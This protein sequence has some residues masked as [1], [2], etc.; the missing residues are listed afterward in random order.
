[1]T[2]ARSGQTATLLADGR[3]LVA[4]GYDGSAVL[5]SAETY[6]PAK[7]TFSRTGS[8]GQPHDGGTAT[9]LPDGEVLM[10]GGV[11]P[12]SPE[13]QGFA[14]AEL[15]DPGTGK[16]RTTGSM[17]QDRWSQAAALLA[18][19]KVLVAG[20]AGLPADLASAELYDPKTGRFAATGSMTQARY[21]LTA[22]SLG[23][24]RVLVA[25]GWCERGTVA[26]AEL[27]DPRTGLFA[28]TGSMEQ[29]RSDH[30]AT[31]LAD[32]R[33]LVAGGEQNLVGPL[34][35]GD[36]L[37]SVELYDPRTSKFS[38]SGAMAQAREDHTATLLRDGSVLVVGGYGDSNQQ[39]PV[40]SAEVWR[41]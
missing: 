6:D 28:A 20:G 35:S 11:D 12:A 41:P 5:T 17:V 25:G 26:S 24:G 34:S 30:T 14:A 37:A 15:Y 8:M 27:F 13:Q 38:D 4:G 19:G 10:A 3:V 23:D 9:L 18:D 29:P 32:G 33:V 31:L 7:G 21:G 40:A 39:V 16:F 36:V 22:T 1:M 2:V